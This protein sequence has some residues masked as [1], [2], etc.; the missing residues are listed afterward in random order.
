MVRQ[1]ASNIFVKNAW[2]SVDVYFTC[3]SSILSEF[4]RGNWI[5]LRQ[6]TPV[7][8]LHVSTQSS[9]SC[10]ETKLGCIHLIMN[11]NGIRHILFESPLIIYTTFKFVLNKESTL[12]E[13]SKSTKKHAGIRGFIYTPCSHVGLQWHERNITLHYTS[14]PCGEGSHFYVYSAT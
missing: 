6:R 2:L 11:Y 3:L 5:L 7:P 9:H 13:R 12:C 8:R 4:V 10:L 1:E 14:T